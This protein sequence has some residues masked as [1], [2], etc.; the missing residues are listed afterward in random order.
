MRK[1]SKGIIIA[2]VVIIAVALLFPIR[3]QAKDGGTVVYN[4]IIY[5]VYKAHRIFSYDKTNGQ[6]S[7]S[8][9]FVVKLFGITIFNNT[10]PHLDI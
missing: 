7:F 4:A 2:V 3:E 5:D 10:T 9:G 1:K 8:E 6:V